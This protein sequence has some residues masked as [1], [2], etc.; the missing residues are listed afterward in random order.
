[1][2]DAARN[3]AARRSTPPPAAA[4]RPAAAAIIAAE[5]WPVA[6]VCVVGA[7]VYANTLRHE[8]VWDDLITL[9][10]RIRFWRSPLD[11]FVE[12]ADVPGFPGVYRPLTFA[13]F[14]IDQWLWWRNPL[15]FHL[16]SVALHVVNGALV[17]ALARALACGR[18]PSTAGALLFAVHP[19]HTEAVA[20]V[21]A[22][23]DVLATT[24]TLIAVVVF[25]R[26]R[27]LGTIDVASAAV[28]AFASFAA[29]ASKEPGTVTPALVALAATLPHPESRT[30][31]RA[32]A[33]S[34]TT[35]T[36]RGAPASAGVA[37]ALRAWRGVAASAIGVLVYFILR[38]V[39]RGNEGSHLGALDAAAL[40]RL[41]RA[42]GFYVERLVAPVGLRAYLPDVP[43]GIGVVL[44]AIAGAIAIAAALRGP[45][46]R[47]AALWIV[48]TLAPSLLVAIAEISV[49]AVAERYLYLP[50]VGL[51]LL[52]AIG[53]SAREPL[54]RAAWAAVAIVL[55]ACAAATALRNEVWHDEITLWTDVTRHE[56]GYALPYMN[57]GLALADAG[58]WDEA[59]AAYRTALDARAS[60]TTLRDVYINL[61]HLQLRRGRYD[62]ALATFAKANAIAPH[63]TALYGIGAAHRERARAAL[64]ARDGATADAEFAA[65]EVALT[66]ALQIN[67]RHFNSHFVLASVLYQ[68]RDYAGALEHYRRVVELAP[69]TEIG[70][71]SAEY[72]RELAA[73]LA[74]PAHRAG[75][76]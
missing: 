32:P 40:A 66:G 52:V 56:H 37:E 42:F 60:P 3:R 43:G 1:M 73:W 47:F 18:A 36:A 38:A 5:W 61:G 35:E 24:F 58:R 63:A 54:G 22:R 7:L 11:A 31:Q 71:K 14:W 62:D 51:A 9:D 13:S 29:A 68:R 53:L 65:A 44:F 12:P 50:S 2:R 64:A 33:P 10:S 20:W 48:L 41:V 6:L 39:N 45:R 25:L 30:A 57:L 76:S 27:A 74:D 17:Y 26:A 23:V 72:A 16:V 59:E 70:A 34:T 8:F 46:T 69:D 55:V 15:G 21:T 75:A 67:P 28:I 49:T 4:S 19:I